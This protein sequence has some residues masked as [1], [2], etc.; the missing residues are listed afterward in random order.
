MNFAFS[1]KS[2]GTKSFLLLPVLHLS[3]KLVQKNHTGTTHTD[4][5][6]DRF[7]EMKKLDRLFLNGL[8]Y[9]FGQY[10]CIFTESHLYE[11]E[12]SVNITECSWE[13]V[14][15]EIN[16][17]IK[18]P[19]ASLINSLAYLISSPLAGSINSLLAVFG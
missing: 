6:K 12:H 10:A 5:P 11:Q 14:F 7:T 4:S 8:H 1:P 18:S 3:Q 17:L 15:W 13:S 2:K 19:F 9:A 16:M